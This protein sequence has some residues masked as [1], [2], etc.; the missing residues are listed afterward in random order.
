MNFLDKIIE[1]KK[2]EVIEQKKHLN[3]NENQLETLCK[4]L[5][6][7]KSFIKKLEKLKNT[8]NI[9]L[10]AEI[11]KASPS[12]GL[13]REN[14]DPVS[15][16]IAYQNAGVH[17]ISVLTDKKFFQ[18]SIQYLKDVRQVTDLPILRKDFII[19]K[20]QIYQTRLMGA[21]II[22][23]IASALEI[24]ILKEYYNLAKSIGLEVLLE[25]HTEKELDLA[26]SLGAKLIGINNRNL[27]TFEVSLDTT[28]NLICNKDLSGKFIISESGINNYSEVKL[29]QDN[30]VSGILAGESLMRQD[31][32]EMAVKSLLNI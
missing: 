21:D 1:Y 7:T 24:S 31:N 10:I 30:G 9:A 19:D 29:L 15:I 16:A 28:L 23:L 3:L 11:K 20:F 8:D 27:E 2:T 6:A 32:I 22:L 5:P 26:V 4:D 25:V 17:A 13:I 14:F 18:G 12:K